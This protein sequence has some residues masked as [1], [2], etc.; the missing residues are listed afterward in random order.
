M[1]R[2]CGETLS[3]MSV[4][5]SCTLDAV[6]PSLLPTASSSSASELT[7]RL[8]ANSSDS[9]VVPSSADSAAARSPSSSIPPRSS[10]PF[11]HRLPATVRSSERAADPNDEPNTASMAPRLAS[12]SVDWSA[13]IARSCSDPPID[14][15]AVNNCSAVARS[16]EPR[17]PARADFASAIAWR[18]ADP[19]VTYCRSRRTRRTRP[20]EVRR[21]R[22]S[23]EQCPWKSRTRRLR[24]RPGTGRRAR[25]L[26]RRR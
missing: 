12:A 14:R 19:T 1:V 18:D 21:P 7:A 25:S 24:G 20:P 9:M 16:I 10:S 23:P 6:S 26:G 17:M 15:A 22:H 13:M 4:W 5:M 3:P 11:D 2:V 8:K